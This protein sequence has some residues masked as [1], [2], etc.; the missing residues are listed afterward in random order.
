MAS[1]R[2]A[3]ALDQMSKNA[4][5][6]LVVDLVRGS[7]G[8]HADEQDV[9]ASLQPFVDAVLRV[10]ND[11]A[12]SLDAAMRKHDHF[13]E[14]FRQRQAGYRSPE[15]LAAEKRLNDYKDEQRK[16]CEIARQHNLTAN[17]VQ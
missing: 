4:L 6:D 1:P 11:K 13:Q 9:A 16:L 3:Y 14:V 15:E 8:E 7:V 10:R 17:V 2:L 12:V 5:A